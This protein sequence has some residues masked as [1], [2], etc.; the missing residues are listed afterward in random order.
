M[1]V[2]GGFA[3]A[4]LSA[5]LSQV[6][7]PT[8]VLPDPQPGIT[9]ALS[10]SPQSGYLQST[11][12]KVLCCLGPCIDVQHKGSAQAHISEQQLDR[13][14]LQLS[15]PGLVAEF[16]RVFQGKPK[17]L[18]CCACRRAPAQVKR[19]SRYPG[20]FWRQCHDSVLPASLDGHLQT[21]L[22][23]GSWLAAPGSACIYCTDRAFLERTPAATPSKSAIAFTLTA[24]VSCA[25]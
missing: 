17:F 5:G 12:P 3:E 23:A 7:I 22:S 6:L 2:L 21:Q 1:W 18:S 14:H 20:G 13:H 24:E 16:R 10:N 4:L 11:V 25:A 8:K 15:I 9:V 19:R